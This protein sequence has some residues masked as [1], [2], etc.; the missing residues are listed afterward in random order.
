M[1]FWNKKQPENVDNTLPIRLKKVENQMI[2]LTM[3][4]ELLRDKVLRKIQ[5]RRATD[6]FPDPDTQTEIR[7]GMLSAEEAKSLTRGQP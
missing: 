6:K 7:K 2:E 3:D 4:M 1:W 5:T